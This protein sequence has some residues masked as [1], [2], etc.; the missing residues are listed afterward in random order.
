MTNNLHTNLKDSTVYTQLSDLDFQKTLQNVFL[1][2]NEKE[3]DVIIKRFSLN[4]QPKQTLEM[5]GK[6]FNVTRER[7]R[8]IEKIALGK[9]KRTIRSTDLVGLQDLCVQV[10]SL[11]GGVLKEQ[12]HIEYVA[13]VLGIENEIEKN[14]IRLNLN[15]CAEIN[16]TDKNNRYHTF[17][18]LTSITEKNVREI[19]DSVISMLKEKGDVITLEEVVQ[20]A[21]E[22][23]SGKNYTGN[24]I[25]STVS[26]D[27][28]LK[29]VEEGVGL[30]TWRHVNPKSIRDKAYIV[31]KKAN[32]PLHFMDIAKKVE[33]AK[34]DHKSVTKQ[35]VHNELIRYDQFVLV[36]RGLYA[37]KE[38]GYEKGTVSSIIKNLLRDHS[39]LTKHE[40]MKGVLEQRQ[41]KKG[42]ISLNLQKNPEFER[43]GRALYSL[44]TDNK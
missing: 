37:L 35:A 11:Y 14:I 16:K 29:V 24:M 26:V 18:T 17:W 6:H 39:P 43:V 1:V 30:M 20:K 22:V 28:R 10:I 8:Q 42:T 19:I 27:I 31:L 13:E 15:V 44:K 33:D 23:H 36:G 21:Q 5:I 38:W 25:R 3:K 2:L 12:D 41:V 9:L 34:F 40:I 7:I 4:G 32:K